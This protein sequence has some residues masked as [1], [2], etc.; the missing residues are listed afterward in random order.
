M[1]KL[2]EWDKTGERYIETGTDRGVLYPRAANGTYPAGVVW[3]GIT[4]VNLSPSGAEA[5]P[6]YA[7][8]IKYI[9]L[10]SVEEFGF[11][12]EAYSS[13]EEFDECDGTKEAA[14]GLKVGQQPRKTFGFAVRTKIGNDQDPNDHGYKLHLIY[15]A[16]AAPSEKAYATINESPEAMTLSW[17]CTTTPVAIPGDQFKPT[18]TLT[19]D[20][21]TAPEAAIEALE[22]ILYG[23]AGESP[24]AA[25]LPLPS[26][27]I[28]LF[29]A[30]GTVV[31]PVAP[32]AVG[33]DVTIPSI[34]GVVYSDGDGPVS[35][36]V[37]TITE[38][39]TFTA[40]PDSGYTFGSGATT[41]WTFT[42]TE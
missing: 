38:D 11:T 33:N 9:T 3:N 18:A 7:D 17:E 37:I 24:T 27:V 36:G 39:T 31:T 8:N 1:A 26:E 14:S 29:E 34:T 20:T 4:A 6:I 5:T 25:R 28:A 23:T 30:A 12:I 42:F 22:A 40:A 19:I 32:T 2:L 21:R 13:P 16:L 10:Q 15:G 41:S 35:A